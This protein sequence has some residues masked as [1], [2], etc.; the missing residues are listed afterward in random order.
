MGDSLSVFSPCPAH[1]CQVLGRAN[2]IS[3][4]KFLTQLW[5]FVDNRTVKSTTNR[6]LQLASRWYVSGALVHFTVRVQVHVHPIRLVWMEYVDCITA[7]IPSLELSANEIIVCVS[8]SES[9]TCKM[10]CTWTSI[11]WLQTQSHPNLS[12]SISLKMNELECESLRE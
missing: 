10:H 6:N 9:E 1:C 2:A 12:L 7:H 5:E 4:R 11:D 3:Q 8:E